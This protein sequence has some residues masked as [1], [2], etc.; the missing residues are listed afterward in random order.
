[1]SIDGS[2]ISYVVTYNALSEVQQV[3]V[4]QAD[5]VDEYR[6]VWRHLLKA[7]R[8]HDTIPSKDILCTRFP[9]IELP[10]VR[11]RDLPL[12]L[13][14]LRSRRKFM[15]FLHALNE[16]ASAVN[17]PE[18]V[19][20]V[21][22]SLQGK[23]NTLS[24]NGNGKQHLVD[25][26]SREAS[27]EMIKEIRKR[28]DGTTLGIPTGFTRFDTVAGGLQ[29][30][31]M[32]TIIGRPGLGKSWLDL[33]FVANAVIYGG[34]FILYPLEMSLTETAFR[35]YTLFSQRM[36][37]TRKA[38]K[39]YDLSTGKVTVAKMVRF[40]HALEDK[41]QG[42][43]YVADVA[44]LGDPYTV[45]RIEAEVDIN[46]P[47]GIWVDYLTL[48][49]PP[50]GDVAGDGG[51]G[52]VRQLSSG[53]A[54][55]AHRRDVVGGVSAQVN[56]EA[57]KNVNVFLP[58]LEHIAY[59]DSIGQDTHQCISINRQGK[60]LYYALVKNRGGP[61]FGKTKVLFDVNGGVLTE[62]ARQDE[63]E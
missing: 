58:R 53:I 44:K 3:G 30:Q 19:D 55:I 31:R 14:Q 24:F 7:K 12:L 17:D 51:W 35:L 63:E 38:I 48:L 22:Q 62:V 11:K 25:L 49:K 20:D 56:R 26:F 57:L 8:E 13:A 15:D 9:D 33:A 1:M 61:E 10:R 6:T 41:F 18:D 47:D 21:V 42:Q 32:I 60:Y 29:K 46:K 52:A 27:R 36:F 50:S 37:G 54:G 23:L 28:R 16:A 39:N 2:I 34:K 5:F 40:F 4:S 43:L 59:G 45:E